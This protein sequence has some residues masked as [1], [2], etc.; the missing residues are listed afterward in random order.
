VR[1]VKAKLGAGDAEQA[2]N[3]AEKTDFSELTASFIIKNGVAHNGDL[4]AKSPFLRISGEGDVNIA[5]DSLNY[6]V[7]AAVVA[8]TAGQ[9]G[10]E[11]AELTGLTLPVRV[12]GPFDG[13]KYKMEF[14]QMLSGANKEALKAG[15]SLSC[16]DFIMLLSALCRRFLNNALVTRPLALLWRPFLFGPLRPRTRFRIFPASGGATRSTSRPWPRRR[17]Q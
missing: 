8:S 6:V 10:K 1:N 2:A 5:E 15:T 9:G 7:K 4:S 11:R 17:A 13:I 12:Y 14:S 16:R 3:Q